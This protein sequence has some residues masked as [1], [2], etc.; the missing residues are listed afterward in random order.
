MRSLE[1]LDPHRLSGYMTAIDDLE[2]EGDQGI[3]LKHACHRS[4]PAD[5]NPGRLTLEHAPNVNPAGMDHLR[6][7][8]PGRPQRRH[9]PLLPT[10]RPALPEPHP[11][12]RRSVQVGDGDGRAGGLVRC[13]PPADAVPAAGGRSSDRSAAA[14]RPPPSGPSGR[15]GWVMRTVRCRRLVLAGV[16]LA[17]VADGQLQGVVGRIGHW[18]VQVASCALAALPSGRRH[19]AL[20]A[21]SELDGA[22]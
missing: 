6:P 16:A 9:H 1:Q 14:N 19:T 12:R 21:R 22:L 8:R 5:E 2:R 20:D 13:R 18:T 11:G 15:R 17:G 7:C 4:D 10:R 3:V